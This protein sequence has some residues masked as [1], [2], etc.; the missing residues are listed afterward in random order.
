MPNLEKKRYSLLLPLFI[1]PLLAIITCQQNTGAEVKESPT[2][3]AA[4]IQESV[5]SRFPINF[6]RRW[7]IFPLRINES[8]RPLDVILDTGMPFRGVILFHKET[9]KEIGMKYNYRSSISGSGQGKVLDTFV[10]AGYLIQ[11]GS[12]SF[13]NEKIIVFDVSRHNSY[14]P[15]D[16]LI[17]K[18]VF[19]EF[20]VEVNVDRNELVLHDPKTFKPGQKWHPIAIKLVRGNLFL[21]TEIQTSSYIKPIN[22]TLMVDCGA[23]HVLQIDINPLKEVT[24]PKNAISGIIGRGLSGYLHGYWARLKSIKIGPFVLK[25]PISVMPEMGSNVGRG[26]EGSLGWGLLNRFNIIFDYGRR[27]I[28]LQP[29]RLF[30][31]PFEGNMAGIYLSLLPGGYAEITQVFDPSP[32]RTADLQEGDIL[33]AVNGKDIS[34]TD[35]QIIYQFFKKPGARCKLTLKRNGKNIEKTI[36]LRRLF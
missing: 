15:I 29:N 5:I 32:A 27:R 8:L 20:V 9:G 24:V 34:K 23:P 4:T 6:N 31:Q 26:G 7:I 11:L 21:E 22:L 30:N 14:F 3:R 18:L 35:Y 17:G 36:K 2:S 19:D 1:L 25:H 12:R 33:I 13:P 10:S 16:G 28:F